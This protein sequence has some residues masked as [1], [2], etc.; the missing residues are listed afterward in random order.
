MSFAGTTEADDLRIAFTHD[1]DLVPLGFNDEAAY[2]LTDE[3]TL[4]E[5]GTVSFADT[6]IRFQEIWIRQ[7]AIGAGSQAWQCM[8]GGNARGFAVRVGS[9]FACVEDAREAGGSYLAGFYSQ[10]GDNWAMILGTEGAPESLSE[11]HPLAFVSAGGGK[12]V[13]WKS[14]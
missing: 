9:H 12:Y 4:V 2:R 3:R 7:S 5:S 10:A 11:A 8:S 6:S 1:I 13:E 14:T